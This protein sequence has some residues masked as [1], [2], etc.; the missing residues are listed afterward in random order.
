MGKG[1]KS[2][3]TINIVFYTH[4]FVHL[5]HWYI[6]ALTQTKLLAEFAALLKD[7]GAHRKNHENA[8]AL[9]SI[10]SELLK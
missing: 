1:W 3:H 8:I 6:Y 2:E 7:T 9:L 5:P 4:I 10:Y